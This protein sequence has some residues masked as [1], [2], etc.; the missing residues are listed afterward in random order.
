MIFLDEIPHLKLYK[1]KTYLPTDRQKRTHG[2]CILLN[3]NSLESDAALMQHKMF[4]NS[5]VNGY[6]MEWMFNGKLHTKTYR[7]NKKKERVEEYNKIKTMVSSRN[8]VTYNTPQNISKRN[9]YYGLHFDN[10]IFFNTVADLS[11][12]RKA[13]LYLQYMKS[14]FSRDVLKDYPMKT[15]LI[16]IKEW[17]AGLRPSSTDKNFNN[18]VIILYYTMRK[19]FDEFKALGDIN[20]VFVFDNGVI[21]VNPSKCDEKSFVTLKQEIRKVN[22]TI[23]NEDDSHLDKL[24]D[25]EKSE[26]V[27]MI[28]SN[29]VDKYNLVGDNIDED[30]KISDKVEDIVSSAAEDSD[31][32]TIEDMDKKIKDSIDG[33]PELLKEIDRAVRSHNSGRTTQS[34]KRDEELKKKQESIK[35]GDKTLSQIT[36]EKIPTLESNNVKESIQSS[37]AN[38]VNVKYPDFEKSYNEHLYKKDIVNIFADLSNKSLPMYVL[39]IDIEDTSDELNLKETWTIKLEDANRQRHTIKVDVPKFLDDKF[40]YLGGNKKI[41]IKQQVMKPIVKTNM[42]TVQIVTNYNKMFVRRVGDKVS[43][44]VEQL[45]KYIT[46]NKTITGVKIKN[47]DNSKMNGHYLTSLEYD[48]LAKSYSLIETKSHRFIFNQEALHEEIEAKKIKI[49]FPEGCNSIVGLTKD[50]KPIY[51]TSQQTI[52]GTNLELIEYILDSMEETHKGIKAEVQDVSAGKRFMYSRAKSMNREVPLILLVSFFQGLST[53]LRKTNVPHYFTDKNPKALISSRQDVIRFNN[54]YLVYDKYPIENALL[55]QGFSVVNTKA[56]DYEDFD[57]RDIYLDIFEEMYGARSLGRYFL[58]VYESMIDPITKEVL[59]TLGY[60]TELCDVLIYA[61]NLLADNSFMSEINMNLYR[62]R[63]NEIVAALLYKVIADEYNN[64]KNIAMVSKNRKMS[65]RQDAVLKEILTS[66]IVEDYSTLNPI[67]ELEKSRAITPKGP[68][69]LN[70][71][72]AYT[73]AKRSFDK[74]MMGIMAISTSPDGNCGVVRSLALEPTIK[75]ARGYVDINDTHIDDLK[76]ANIFSPAE[77]LTPI[78]AARDDSNRT[79]MATKQ[80]K[81]IIPVK[82]ASPVL[83]SNGAEQVIHYH[84]GDDF[85]IVAEDDGEVI[86]VDEKNKLIFIKYKNGK[87][88]AIDI[89]TKVV[90]NGAGGFYLPNQLAYDLKK[91]QKFKKNDILAY[92]STFFTNNINGNRFN[93]GTLAKVA[94]FCTGETFED[95]AFITDK[96]AHDLGSDIVMKKSV[97]LKKNSS[98]ENMVKIGQHIKSGDELIKFETSYEEDYLNDLL[99]DIGDD[100]SEEIKS[101]GKKPIKS[102]YTGD[103]IDIQIYHTV[104]IDELSPSLK[105]VVQEHNKVVNSRKKALDKYANPG[106]NDVYKCGMLF[107]SASSK[108]TTKD[109]KIKGEYVGDGVLIEFYIKYEDIAGIG[110]KF[111]NFTALKSIIGNVVPKGEEPFSLFRPDEEVSAFIPPGAILARMTPSIII[112]LFGNKVLIELKRKLQ[113]IYEK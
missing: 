79:A 58:N 45:K 69:G 107:N 98:I 59:E 17:D 99:K 82:E 36:S 100:L 87:T 23:I 89:S 61:N 110:D 34:L 18:P 102:K 13:S 50:N 20:I 4:E 62:I 92:H 11:Y 5:K 40:M 88:K 48:Y 47:G 52:H 31:G 113:E 35:I 91:G 97:T 41:I 90:R 65:I 60:P 28:S 56:Y 32:E 24:V 68:S 7:E 78:G 30:E 66:Q 93:I 57:E 77:M 67:V 16:N 76:D 42:D 104:D 105:K 55:L 9:F 15:M 85:S 64:Y 25:S 39:D 33:D 71:S 111:A 112:T 74:S 46:T 3:T 12:R 19:M 83:M 94:V 63:S 106:D 86:E 14:F 6:Y 27:K 95:S 1:I 73:E 37:N 81:H 84:L 8:I 72:R 53:T 21:S 70:V 96:L 80:S 10:N 101:Y 51:L 26:V 108:V 43:L 44:A 54:G 2:S 109:G 29:F 103:I 38:I 22:T 75:N 49:V